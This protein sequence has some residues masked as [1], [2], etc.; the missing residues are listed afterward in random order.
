[1]RVIAKANA[2]WC[3]DWS[4]RVN[5]SIVIQKRKSSVGTEWHGYMMMWR[6][7]RNETFFGSRVLEMVFE[8]VI[9]H[10]NCLQ[11]S[12]FNVFHQYSLYNR[13]TILT[14]A[15]E[16]FVQQGFGPGKRKEAGLAGSEHWHIFHPLISFQRWNFSGSRFSRTKWILLSCT[17]RHC[18]AVEGTRRTSFQKCFW[19]WREQLAAC[20]LDTQDTFESCDSEVVTGSK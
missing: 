2:E 13:S 10:Q 12:C 17:D 20:V 18:V 14:F 3:G 7:V 9:S 6:R 1:M 11:T 15:G 19:K 4:I 16:R 8:L 5:L